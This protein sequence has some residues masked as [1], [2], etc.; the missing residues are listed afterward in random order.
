MPVICRQVMKLID[1]AHQ[2]A[3]AL[4]FLAAMNIV[5]RDMKLD[6]L[7]VAQDGNI[8]VGYPSV[9]C[10]ACCQYNGVQKFSSEICFRHNYLSTKSL[11]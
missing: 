5:H 10:Y 8:K 6:N 9:M 11:D 2:V 1:W 3:E 7:L 4:Y